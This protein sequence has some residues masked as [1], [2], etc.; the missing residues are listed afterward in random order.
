[1]RWSGYDI[2]SEVDEEVP[3]SEPR[4]GIV[5]MDRRVALLSGRPRAFGA[6]WYL[7]V[8]FENA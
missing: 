1:M 8:V 5:G 3:K 6:V 4:K 2:F 7:S